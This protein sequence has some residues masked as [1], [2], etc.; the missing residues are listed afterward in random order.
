[1]TGVKKP[2]GRVSLVLLYSFV[3]GG[4]SRPQSPWLS[5]SIVYAGEIGCQL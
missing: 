5:R 2:V 4:G 3:P 1:M